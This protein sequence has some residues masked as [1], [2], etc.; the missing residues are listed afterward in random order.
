MK[1][2]ALKDK[3]I[4]YK[5]RKTN[6]SKLAQLRMAKGLTQQQLADLAGVNKQNIFNIETG[7]HQPRKDMCEKIASVLDCKLYEIIE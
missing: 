7:R 5:P 1:G 6:D 3:S 2:G 4:Y